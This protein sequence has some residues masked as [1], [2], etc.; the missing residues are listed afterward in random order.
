MSAL[1][2]LAGLLL[3][4][5]VGLGVGVFVGRVIRLGEVPPRLNRR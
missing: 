2:V 1:V 5:V 3:W 4:F